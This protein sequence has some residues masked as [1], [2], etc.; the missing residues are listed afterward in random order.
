MLE[1]LPVTTFTFRKIIEDGLLYV[2]KTRYLYELVR[3]PNRA[4]FLSRPRRFG[5]SLLISTL[6]E[7]LSGNR[8]LF[9]DLWFGQSDYVWPIHPV[10]HFDLSRE[11]IHTAAELERILGE[12][13]TEIASEHGLS[14]EPGPPQR[15]FRHLIRQMA[16]QNQVVILIDEYDKPIIDNIE[17]LEE[18]IRIRDTLKDFYGVI[19]SA[20]AYLHLAFITGISK[21]SQ[22]GVFSAL[23]NLVDLTLNT[24]FSGLL[25][26]TEAEIKRDFADHIDALAHKTESTSDQL[27]AKLAHW[28]DGF[29]FAAEGET[30]YNPY[31]VIHLFYHQ[32]FAN[33]WFETGTPTFLIKLIR[34]R[35]YEIEHIETVDLLEI[36]FKSYEI[37]S[38]E[39]VPLLFQT[40][41]LTIKSSY[42]APSGE[43]VYTLAYPNY[44]VETA[45]LTYLL[46]AFSYIERTRVR[47]T[48]HRLIRALRAKDLEQV[49]EVMRVFFANIPYDLQLHYE[50]YYQSIFYVLFMLI[51]FDIEVEVKTN[52]GRIDAV[53][54]LPDHIFLFEFKLDQTAEAALAQIKET[55]YY[56]K[57]ALRDQPLTLVRA[58]FNSHTRSV[59]DWTSEPAQP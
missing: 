11:R 56:E 48:L 57:Y 17:N 34:D 40:G 5:K 37:E 12:Y 2:D 9:Q 20:D 18:A 1:L 49:F 22:V 15:Q 8:D 39:I 13:L 44:E 7:I 10:I 23:N 32:R 3:Y 41:Y 55:A 24:Q 27:L 19:K 46:N 52:R 6:A 47:S 30:V 51:G 54:V 43:T 59:D 33:Y 25:G 4:Y 28:Y 42:L 29:C 45:F 26:L 38:L 50:Q 14:I 36:D 16:A 53:V 21:F 58:N 35:N 31:S